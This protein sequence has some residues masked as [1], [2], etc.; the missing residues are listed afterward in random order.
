MA[1]QP[2]TKED[3]TFVTIFGNSHTGKT[4]FTERK[5]INVDIEAFIDE[6]IADHEKVGLFCS[7]VVVTIVFPPKEGDYRNG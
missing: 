3:E 7:S 5:G 1:K 6:Y 4:Q 2:E